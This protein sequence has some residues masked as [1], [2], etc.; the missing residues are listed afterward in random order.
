MTYEYKTVPFTVKVLDYEG[1][2]IEGYAAVFGNIDQG[3]DIIHRGAFAKTLAERGNQVKFLW[4]HDA[5]EPLGRPIELHEDDNGLYIK[6]VVS[7]TARGRD[8]LALLR[9]GAIDGMSI[10]Y[11]AIQG[12]TDY[13]KENGAPVRNLREVR[14]WEFSLVTFPMNERAA[15][16]ALKAV[17]AFQDFALADRDRAWDS[18]AADGRVREWA[19]A[20]EEPTAD[21]ARAFFWHDS[22][23]PELYTSYKFPYVDIV[24]GEPRA[25]FRAIA[26]GAARLQQSDIP[27][28][29]KERIA[30]QMTRYYRKAAATYDDDGIVS[31]FEKSKAV[32]VGRTISKANEQRLLAALENAHNAI[33]A[34]EELLDAAG[35][36]LETEPPPEGEEEMSDNEK[37]G[38]PQ[39]PTKQDAAL[40]FE[41]TIL[42]T[43]IASMEV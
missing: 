10:G 17:T 2:T 43:Q 14:L 38:P 32:K 18:T 11:D 41:K 6:A 8:A 30:A 28:A 42:L 21:Y 24:D 23:A 22:D 9:D 15:V 26:N 1:R 12:G 25:V 36:T 5:G 39:A 31:P 16:T 33:S 13:S 34:I 29:D 27:A 35:I 37:A 20:T 4:Q 7:D 19:G 40:E 3:G